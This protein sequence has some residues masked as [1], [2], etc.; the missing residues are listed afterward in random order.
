[1]AMALQRNHDCKPDLRIAAIVEVIAIVVVDVEVIGVIPVV[2]PVFRPWINHQERKSAVL[3]TRI[4]QIHNWL[5]ANAEEVLAAERET[6]SVLR[7]VVTAV[8]SALSPAP[9][10]GRPALGAIL[11]PG[12][13]PLPRAALL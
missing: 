10:V 11:L 3:K 13:V 4:S 12:I 1:M 6:E 7:H 9:M 5:R 8:A 2:G